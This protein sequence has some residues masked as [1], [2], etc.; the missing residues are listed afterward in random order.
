MVLECE[1]GC[2]AQ[3]KTVAQHEGSQKQ[4]EIDEGDGIEEEDSQKAAGKKEDD[5]KDECQAA[6]HRKSPPEHSQIFYG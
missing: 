1:T 4:A 6:S 3:E 2:H 5:G